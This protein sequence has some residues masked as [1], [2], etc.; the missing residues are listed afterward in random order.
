MVS[1]RK[2]TQAD[3]RPIKQ[4]TNQITSQPNDSVRSAAPHINLSYKLYP[5]RPRVISNQPNALGTNTRRGKA[6]TTT[7]GRVENARPEVNAGNSRW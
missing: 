4:P 6:H 2:Q 7:A 1:R 5:T 3:A